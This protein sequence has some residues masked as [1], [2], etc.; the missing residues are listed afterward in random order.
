MGAE[1][2]GNMSGMN[3]YAMAA[4]GAI[5]GI[6]EIFKLV[7]SGKDKRLAQK[8]LD[9][10]RPTYRTPEEVYRAYQRLQML[11]GQ[12]LPGYGTMQGNLQNTTQQGVRALQELNPTEAVAGTASLYGNQMAGQRELDMQQAMLRREGQTN[13]ANFETGTL[14]P[15]KDQ[16]FDINK[17][18][19][20]QNAQMAARALLQSSEQNKFG[21]LTGLSRIGVGLMS[22]VPET[23]NSQVSDVNFKDFVGGGKSA[24]KFDVNE[25]VPTQDQ[26]AAM[27]RRGR[28]YPSKYPLY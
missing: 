8:Y 7:Q 12:P 23:A 5:S 24:M 2:I 22:Q 27:M 25:F 28:R 9:T 17:F 20:Y 3:P 19:P 21:G 1:S 26:D 15:Y 10:P 4:G 14:A 18:Q 6:S 11:G 16:E 13:L